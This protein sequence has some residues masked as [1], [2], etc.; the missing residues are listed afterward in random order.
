MM[1]YFAR[2]KMFR[3]QSLRTCE[4]IG[5]YVFWAQQGWAAFQTLELRALNQGN[6]LY[7]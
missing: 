7:W 2:E 6:R 1:G 3:K 4:E 5:L